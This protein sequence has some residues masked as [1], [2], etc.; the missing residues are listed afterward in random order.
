MAL[1]W[2]T[3]AL[4]IVNFLVLVWL[5]QRYLY[6]PVRQIVDRRRE[7]IETRLNEAQRL[8]QQAE[9]MQQRYEARLAEWEAEKRRALENLQQ[10]LEA[11]RKHRLESLAK[12]LAAERQKAEELWARE[13]QDRARRLEEQ[14]LVLGAAFIARLLERLADRHLH[15]RLLE[16]LQ[17]DLARWPAEQ[18]IKLRQTFQANPTPVTVTSAFALD[19]DER[20]RLSAAL[21]QLLVTELGSLRFVVDPKLLAGVRVSLGTYVLRANLQDELEFF[22]RSHASHG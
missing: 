9:A 21:R 11:E 12:E 5:I 1:N 8:R 16:L 15:Q 2:S 19:E 3:F 4:E 14:A 10:E 17:E 13:Q 22:A 7:E 6:R 20:D 18:V